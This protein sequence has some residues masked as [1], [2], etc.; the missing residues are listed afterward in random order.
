MTEYTTLIALADRLIRKKGR[1]IIL[2]RVTKTPAANEWEQPSI[3]NSDQTIK[4]VFLGKLKRNINGEIIE[5][6]IETVLIA[7]LDLTTVP[8]TDDLII[9]GSRQR[10]IV[11]IEPVKPGDESVFYSIGLKE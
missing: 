6:D 2:R 1:T 5:T 10:V 4:G 3:V 7:A 9:D 11:K 8:T